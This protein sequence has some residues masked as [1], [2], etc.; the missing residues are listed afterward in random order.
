C[1][2]TTDR[3]E[4]G[5]A[6]EVQ[7]IT[8]APFFVLRGARGDAHGWREGFSYPASVAILSKECRRAGGAGGTDSVSL[9]PRTL[10]GIAGNPTAGA[11]SF[12]RWGA[13]TLHRGHPPSR[14]KYLGQS[15][16]G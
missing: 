10:Q 1:P 12:V 2:R 15:P 5:V 7:S 14:C 8:T 16:Q 11:R 9:C 13:S 3:G 4:G 6:Q